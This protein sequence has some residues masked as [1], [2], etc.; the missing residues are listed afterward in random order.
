MSRVARRSSK[1]RA[2]AAPPTTYISALTPTAVELC[3][4]SGERGDD[5]VP[6]HRSDPMQGALGDEHPASPEGGRRLGYRH[7]PEAGHL[8][9]EPEAV[10]K[11]AG[12]DRPRRPAQMVNRGEVLG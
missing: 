12:L 11:A 6:V 5:L 10:Q 8:A 3:R 2:I 4:Q 7:R 9:D 1:A